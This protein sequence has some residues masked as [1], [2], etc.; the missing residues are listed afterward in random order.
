VARVS[1]PLVGRNAEL[2][3]LTN[4]IEVVPANRSMALVQLV[5]EAGIGKSRLLSETH[6]VAEAAGW[7]ALGGQASEFESEMPF[8][9]FVDALDDFLGGLNLRAI[10]GLDAQSLA[11]LGTVFPAFARLAGDAVPALYTERHRTYRAVRTLLQALSAVDPLLLT[12]DDAHWA[13]VPSAELLAYL[14]AHPIASQVL[15]ITAFRPVPLLPALS[16]S[17]DAAT[18]DSRAERLV[19]APLT[20]SESDELL[21]ASV[22]RAD[23][24]AIYQDSGG[25]P[26][27]LEQLSRTALGGPIARDS[28]RPQIS[29]G[30]VPHAVRAAL[31]SELAGL[32]EGSSELLRS[33]AV[34]G[35]P[36]E[37]SLAAE[38]CA[39][40]WPDALDAVDSLLAVG[41]V[42]ATSGSTVFR[43][44]H[45]IVR[46]AVYESATA[47]W[48]VQAHAKAAEALRRRGASLGA[49][50]HHLARSARPGDFDAIDELVRAADAAAP[51]APASAAQWYEAALAL[52]PDGD[53]HAGRRVQLLVALAEATGA[54]GQLG[55]SHA[56]LLQALALQPSGRSPARLVAYCAT[57]EHLLGRYED[58]QRR[59]LDAVDRL[60]DHRSAD[61][62]V[63]KVALSTTASYVADSKAMLRWAEEA[64]EASKTLGGDIHSVNA[65]GLAA[66]AAY[67]L[68]MTSE[69]DRHT[70][71]AATLLDELDD[72]SLGQQIDA[73]MWVGMSE[74]FLERFDEGMRHLERGIRVSRA[75]GQGQFILFMMHLQCWTLS[76]TGRLCEARRGAEEAAEAA[77][78]AGQ[79]YALVANLFERSFAAGLQ[80]D[81]TAAV[82]A[83]GEGV[84]IATQLDAGSL[85]SAAGTALGIALLDAGEP[86]RA[87]RTILE[88]GGGPSLPLVGRALLVRAYEALALADVSVGSVSEAM[89]WVEHA[90]TATAGFSLQL[91]SAIARRAR[92]AVLLAAG[93]AH[94]AVDAARSAMEGAHWAGAPLEAARARL[95]Y[96]RALAS[97]GQRDEA[98]ISVDQALED[99]VSYG[100]TGYADEAARELRRLGRGRLVRS[101]LRSV[102]PRGLEA[103]SEREWDIARR[104]ALGMTNRD[105]AAACFL[106]EK[107]VERHLTHIFTK[108]A[109]STRSALAGLVSRHQD[110]TP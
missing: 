41:L 86:E 48:R 50:A 69:A 70:V 101:R 47:G 105:I 54:A 46:R 32:P 67:Q 81:L 72:D 38:V 29:E 16:G 9:L 73:A 110:T 25:N 62:V 96:G 78:V 49:V 88:T 107:T 28:G 59:L 11:E 14:V 98:V 55:E 5:G 100:A 42:S 6:R 71:R 104:V 4:A 44:R 57:I 15:L 85:C 74:S 21:G 82:A 56:A 18:K 75:T 87:R 2:D 63:L 61:A 102:D 7:I 19:L 83:G 35:D 37:I 65:G 51:R 39:M 10:D 17:L 26:F 20:R 80:G 108:L 93:S 109:I 23:L 76:C 24:A 30:P 68:G 60:V 64:L 40:E 27:Y 84:R 79:A 43:F 95:L 58:G 8:A 34:L 31:A 36:F 52:V 97:A 90:E 53:A 13:D 89:A 103:L 92:A 1:L 33:G 66:H 45:P 91:E 22:A 77:R 94:E 99:L 12:L 3:A 106:S